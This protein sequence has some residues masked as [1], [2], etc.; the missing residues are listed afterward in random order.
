MPLNC[1]TEIKPSHKTTINEI[2]FGFTADD[3]DI[4]N[5]SLLQKIDTSLIICSL[6][7]IYL[8]VN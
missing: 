6:F 5:Y 7:F 2:S 4:F 8:Y 1:I 3:I